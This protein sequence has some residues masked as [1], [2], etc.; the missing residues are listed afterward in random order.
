LPIRYDNM[1]RTCDLE[2]GQR[3]MGLVTEAVPPW[4]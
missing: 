4:K 1:N 2:R 3:W